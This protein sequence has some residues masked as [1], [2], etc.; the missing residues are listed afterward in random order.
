MQY[1]VRRIHIARIAET[2][3]QHLLGIESV[4]FLSG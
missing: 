2:Y 4:K 1:I 3:R